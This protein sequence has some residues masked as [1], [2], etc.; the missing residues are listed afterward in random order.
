MGAAER[1]IGTNTDTA[2]HKPVLLTVRSAAVG[3][4][5]QKGRIGTIQPVIH[6]DLDQT[7]AL[8]TCQ[9]D[10]RD[11]LERLDLAGAGIAAIHVNAAIEHLQQNLENAEQLNSSSSPFEYGVAAKISRITH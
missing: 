5:T 2:I 8:Q 9:A 10:L 7:A 3:D 4:K 1:E 6:L 11:V